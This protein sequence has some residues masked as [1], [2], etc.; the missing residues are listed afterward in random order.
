M[1]EKGLVLKADQDYWSDSQLA[2]LSQLG[3]QKASKGDL[4][5]FFH[6]AQRT[7]LDPFARQIYMIERSGRQTIQTSIDGLRIVAQRSNNYGGQTQAEWCGDDGVWKDVWL[8]KV[9]PVA[10][11]VGVYYKDS[12]HATYAVAKWDSYA[13]T[14]SPIWKKMPDLMLAK[15]AEA[16]A[17]RK[18]FPNDL[19]GL[20]TNDEMA[21]A[22]HQIKAEAPKTT[23]VKPAE[24]A[25]A[26]VVPEFTE[27]DVAEVT[28]IIAS[29]LWISDLDELRT[30]WSDN[31]PLLECAGLT[32]VT[33]KD[34]ISNR[35]AEVKAAE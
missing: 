21:Q 7:G 27:A 33:L 2:A 3:I 23:A 4:Q 22:D 14:T 25:E 11:R 35:V 10:A 16:L 12:P 1:A 5:V 30:I 9:N 28:A 26:E 13:V 8:A 31:K 29:I 19:S 20:Y 34:A 15:C 24:L 18:A 32:G 17:L 6:Q